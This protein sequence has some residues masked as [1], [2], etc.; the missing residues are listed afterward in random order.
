MLSAKFNALTALGLMSGTSMD[1]IDV[2]VIR[3]DGE[4]VEETGPSSTFPY[5]S[6]FRAQLNA[7]TDNCDNLSALSSELTRAH[8]TAVT[9]F[10]ATHQMKPDE[11]DLVGFHGHTVKHDPAGGE[12]I[13]IGSGAALARQ[14]GI[15]VVDQFRLADVA[16]GG[17]GAPLAP[18]YHAALA[19]ELEGPLAVLN[20]GGVANVTWIGKSDS[21]GERPAIAAFDTGPGNALLDD[22]AISQIGC[23][24]DKDGCLA[25]DGEIDPAV[26]KHFVEH[27]YFQQ[28][29]P[30]SLDRNDFTLHLVQGL[31]APDG[32]ATLVA[33][34]AA[35]VTAAVCHFPEAP[36]S[37][38]VTG[39]GRKNPAIM[40]A[41]SDGL[42][43]PVQPVESVGWCGDSLEAQ[44]FAFLAVRSIRGLPITLPSTTGVPRPLTGGQWHRAP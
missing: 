31:S 17:Q 38:L 41:L 1:G 18:L 33:M 6:Q 23:A 8:S 14:L 36:T 9:S 10:L 24:M 19:E 22:W 27:S 16:A 37:W 43:V 3:S 15:D 12:T 35:G 26:F 4:R 2:A 5:S 32:A 20:I 29:P 21:C 11:V 13:Q 34:T 44:A 42:S 25:A 40:A 28:S 30:K 39:G 7:A